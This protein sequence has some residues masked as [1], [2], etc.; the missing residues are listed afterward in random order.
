[1][2]ITVH[3][4]GTRKD[5]SPQAELTQGV[6]SESNCPVLLSFEWQE[7]QDGQVACSQTVTLGSAIWRF[8]TGFPPP[9]GSG[10]GG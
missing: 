3:A 1:M 7:K 4:K 6:M 5:P 8:R 9:I 10:A 2:D